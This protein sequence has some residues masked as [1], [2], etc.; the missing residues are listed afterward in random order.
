MVSRHTPHAPDASASTPSTQ[1][2]TTPRLSTLDLNLLLV[3]DAIYAE[4]SA[5]RAGQRLGLSQSAVSHALSRLRERL[6]DELFVKGSDG[7]V[8]TARARSVAPRIHTAL[9]ALQAALGDTQFDPAASEHCFTI[10]ADPYARAMLL[11]PLITLLRARAPRIE[12]RVRPGFAGLTDAL[13]SGEIDLV[14]ASYS[15]VPARYGQLDILEERHVWA[16]RA[17]HAAADAP[18]T[19]ERLADLAHIVRV[20]PG[21]EDAGPDLPASGRGLVRRAIQDDDGAFARALASIGRRRSIRLTMPDSYAALSVVGNS[22][23]AA[24]VP[25]RMGRQLAGH[26]GLRLFDPPYPSPCVRLSMVWDLGNG[27]T[28]A[29][30]WLRALIIEAARELDAPRG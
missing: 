2:L 20:V 25:E 24:L 29:T 13:D 16:L 7:M 17:D 12:L 9:S 14:L 8:P 18:L 23:L 22:D 6:G 4:R 10:A 3:F 26:F 5:T 15:K 27:S 11:P 1:R 21:D 19:L 28:S 30:A